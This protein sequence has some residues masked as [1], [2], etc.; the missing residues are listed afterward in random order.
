MRFTILSIIILFASSGFA[1]SLSKK[2]LPS[3]I[4]AF[5]FEKT[6]TDEVLKILGAPKDKKITNNETVFFYNFKGIDFDTSLGFRENKLHYIHLSQSLNPWTYSD[7]KIF[8]TELDLQKSLRKMSL[9]QGHDKG[10]TFQLRSIKEGFQGG[11]SS[12]PKKDL[13]S[14][15]FWKAG[16][17]QP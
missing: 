2:I 5:V 12:M 8:F 13:V 16:M 11:F 3:Q 10:K 17:P 7:F 15:T 14:I 4:S 1:T 9:E 6:T